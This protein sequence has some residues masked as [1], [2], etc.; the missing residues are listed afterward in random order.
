MSVA[1]KF[2]KKFGANLSESLGARTQ[3]L[4]V[5]PK[6][7]VATA[8]PDDG[9]TRAREAG[10]M[11]VERIVPDPNQPRKEF[12]AEALDQLAESLKRHGQLLPLRVRWSE[13]L[14][15]WVIISG[16]RRYQAAK[17]AGLKTLSCVFVDRPLTDAEILQEQIIENLL[18]EDLKPIEQ[19]KAYKSLMD[20][21]GWNGA[22]VAEALNVSKATISR[23]LA[24]LKLP[25][26][27]QDQIEQGAI[28][29]TAGYELTKLPTDA[30]QREMAG[31][32]VG[33][34]LNRR[35]AIDAVREAVDR[36]EAPVV[37]RPTLVPE[38]RGETPAAQ[39]PTKELAQPATILTGEFRGETPATILEPGSTASAEALEGPPAAEVVESTPEVVPVKKKPGKPRTGTKERAY[40]VDGARV[41]ITFSKKVPN[42]DEVIAALEQAL[43]KA[44]EAV[45]G[46]SAERS[47][48]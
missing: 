39:I 13:E 42:A 7:T 2:T 30:A 35:D 38:F 27:I 48:A 45:E 17:R 22:Q 46:Q 19:A 34:S 24:L 4:S 47:A 11:E 44:R 33:E 3:P 16:E 32:I 28:P 25:D 43:E 36:A 12:D 31:R 8:S 29:A 18:R 41:V 20:T 5:A 26:D 1:E 15:K 23:V 6:K 37:T 21:Q 9:R 14:A 10:F 40:R